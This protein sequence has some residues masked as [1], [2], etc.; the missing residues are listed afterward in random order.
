MRI[1]I[2]LL[3]RIVALRHIRILN[4]QFSIL[5]YF[6]LRRTEIL[7]HGE[8]GTTT[9]LALQFLSHRNT[10]THDDNIDIV[11]GTLEED[12]AHIASHDVA[13]HPQTVGYTT[14]LVEDILV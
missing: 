13:F 3:A 11:G 6:N 5:N 12:V 8:V 2:T 1:M 7:E 9:Q 4:S 14:N 10:A